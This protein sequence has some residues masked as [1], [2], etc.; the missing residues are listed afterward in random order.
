MVKEKFWHKMPHIPKRNIIIITAAILLVTIGGVLA[1]YIYDS[2]GSNL[3]FA[4]EFYFTSNLLKED[5]A[6]YILNSTAT[7]VS[8]TLG[9]NKDKLRVSQVDITYTVSVETKSG[10]NAPEIIHSN[11]DHILSKDSIHEATI[12]LKNLVKGET[13]IV[14]A[15][16]TSGYK[17]ILRAE[18]TVSDSDETIYMNLDTSSPSYVLLT[19][20]TNNI[21]GE[22]YVSTPADLIPDNTDP[23]L[24]AVYNYNGSGYEKIE[25]T[26]KENFNKKYS[27]YTYRFF[28]DKQSF[29]I[30]N[31]T[32]S[33]NTHLA[34]KTDIPK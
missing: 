28:V 24:R 20:W 17:Q 33:I 27:S 9:N 22:L 29:N 15:I 23:V 19:V 6:K 14:T 1:K 16:G 7:E 25:F 31:F 5:T 4:K 3:M 30:E 32:A 11:T 12:T 18:F 10:G 34:Q 21:S 13:Y 8:F 26:D 2:F